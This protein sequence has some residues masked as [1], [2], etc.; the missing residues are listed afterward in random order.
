MLVNI[1]DAK[2]KL[3]ALIDSALKGEEVIIGKKG[4][5]MVILTPVSEPKGKRVF[6][7]H[8][9]ALKIHGDI[10]APLDDDFMSHFE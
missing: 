10:N 6:G 7:K 3:S 9:K 1:Y 4:V 2:A 5:P 8:S